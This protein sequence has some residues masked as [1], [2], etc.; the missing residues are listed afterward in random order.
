MLKRQ[1]ILAELLLYDKKNGVNTLAIMHKSRYQVVCVP[2]KRKERTANQHL[3]KEELNDHT[4][5]SYN[6]HINVMDKFISAWGSYCKGNEEDA[7][8]MILFYLAKRNPH[9]FVK[10]F[11]KA[12]KPNDK[13]GPPEFPPDFVS[14]DGTNDI[15]WNTR[16]S[17]LLKHKEENGD[18]RVYTKSELGR[19]VLSLRSARVQ[20]QGRVLLTPKRVE[21]LDNIGTYMEPIP[22]FVT[23]SISCAHISRVLSITSGFHWSGLPEGQPRATPG[24]DPMQNRAIGELCIE[25]DATRIFLIMLTIIF[26]RHALH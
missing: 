3:D 11:H 14:H 22:I 19:W 12:T 1:D 23:R 8:N 4:F 6:Q 2:L 20:G 13:G 25:H 18:C 21:L 7:I 9:C 10:T 5:L 16:Y 15:K 17:E 26:C 24:G